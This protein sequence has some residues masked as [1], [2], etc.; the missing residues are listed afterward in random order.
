MR[1]GVFLYTQI[2]SVRQ[3]TR[4]TKDII[5]KYQSFMN[6]KNWTQTEAAEE[7]GCSQEHLSRIFRGLKNP[8]A[9]LLDRMEEVMRNYGY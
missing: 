9:K 4:L 3:V 5:E 8:S 6:Y 1:I 2:M 7:V